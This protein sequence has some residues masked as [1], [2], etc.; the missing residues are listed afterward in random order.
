MEAY[1]YPGSCGIS[2]TFI[3]FSFF[4]VVLAMETFWHFIPP[5]DQ[6]QVADIPPQVLLAS[7][8]LFVA[9]SEA[10]SP[11]TQLLQTFYLDLLD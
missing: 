10:F 4:G 3:T 7:L 11:S 5:L 8:E 1:L 9:L 2:H 6:G